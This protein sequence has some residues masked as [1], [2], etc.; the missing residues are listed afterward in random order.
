MVLT[1]YLDPDLLEMAVEKAAFTH[2]ALT[3]ISRDGGYCP[4]NIASVKL[5][6]DCSKGFFFSSSLF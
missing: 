1:R 4:T 6:M 2:I 5:V 3:D